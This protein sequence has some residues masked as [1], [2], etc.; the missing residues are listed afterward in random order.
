MVGLPRLAGIQLQ[1]HLRRNGTRHFL[2]D[3]E[4]VAQFHLVALRP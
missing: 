4:D 2:L 3:A 1:A